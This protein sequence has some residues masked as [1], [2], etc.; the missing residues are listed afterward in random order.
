MPQVCP[1]CQRVNP[2]EAQFCYQ[3]GFALGGRNGHA[4]P[5]DPGSQPFP[6]PFVFPNGSVC[7]NFDQLALAC[8]NEWSTAVELLRHGDL[9]NFLAGL[10]RADLA[11]AARD[12]SKQ[13]DK[14][15]ALDQLL[16]QLP[17]NTIEPAKLHVETLHL[18]LGQLTVGKDHRCDLR[19]VNQGMRMLSGTIAV[20]DCTWLTLG[21]GG[22]SPRKVFQFQT[23]T[24]IPVQVRGKLLR[25][26]AK[27]VQ[28]RLVIETNGGAA[29]VVVTADVPVKP[30]AE[31][32]LAGAVTPRQIAEKAKA[33][34]RAA[35]PLFESGAVARWYIQNGWTYPVQGPAASGIGAVQQFFEALGLTT[36]PRVEV[37]EH[38]LS[39]EARPG[40]SVS[41]TLDVSAVE[42]RPVFASAVSDQSWLKVSKVVLDGRTAHVKLAVESAPDRPGETLEAKLTVRANG[43]QRFVIP[44]SLRVSGKPRT[45]TS[46]RTT[47]GDGIFPAL[48]V[49]EIADAASAA[50]PPVRRPS[51]PDPMVRPWRPPDAAPAPVLEAVPL[52]DE[53]DDDRRDR[54]KGRGPMGVI[55]PLLP[56]VCI[57]F[58]LF[59]TAVR[60]GVVW[61]LSPHG[62]E[63]PPSLAGGP[64][65]TF[66]AIHF[67][68]QTKGVTL[69]SGGVKGGGDVKEQAFWDPTMRFGLVMLNQSDQAGLPKRLTYEEEGLTNN[70][71]VRIDGAERLFGEETFEGVP[72][73]RM[74]G[75]ARKD[76]GRWTEMAGDLGYDP[77]GLKREGKRSVWYYDPEK[78]QI[79][80]TVELVAGESGQVDTCLVRY[81]I[82]NQDSRA[83]TIGLRFLLD[84][85]IGGNDGVPFLIPGQDQ[86][87]DDKKELQGKDLPQYIQALENDDPA[88]PG[89][90]A[91]LQLKLGGAIE[92]PNRVTLGAYPD[93]RLRDKMRDPR[94]Q[95]E[96]TKW[97]VPV[98]P[99]KSIP[100]GDS[101]VTMYWPI[102]SLPAGRS[103]ELGFAYG[104]GDV[105]A[106]ESGGKLGLTAD[107]D[108]TPGGELTVTAYVSNPVANQTVNLTL[109]AGFSVSDGGGTTRPVPPAAGGVSRMSPVTWKVKAGSAGEYSLKVDSS[110]GA[111]QSK[112]I[113]I[114]TR[115]LFGGN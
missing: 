2:A 38:S 45:T 6:H 87:C 71:C 29:T 65:A 68:D 110:N 62:L 86:L 9:A 73:R 4:G 28:G 109:P 115:T 43:N 78:V 67:H 100:P 49:V 5:V 70:C 58:G 22:G 88:H 64:G 36:P 23:A 59:V 66:I 84:T 55:L 93:P 35:A 21:E 94:C 12:A 14:D 25:A 42:K 107:G 75:T 1:K 24:S 80:Q 97:D 83:H 50:P 33:A 8:H 105:A 108:R 103:R 60:D 76:P 85:Y 11:R 48:E 20:S 18:N 99:I 81:K 79:T 3:D 54:R 39:F 111:T 52:D 40:G 47:A 51:A 112:K 37:R 41:H 61:A 10:G 98:Y 44:V 101:C 69:G 91:R 53:E 16:G 34:P 7:R 13:A 63:G 26:A 19:L 31:G 106:S 95:Q 56:V 77:N 102:E 30:F 72:F 90:I 114:K 15:H 104:L 96:Q 46:R 113:T 92:P 89:T 82:D 17:A 27:P 32:V 57:C 74:N